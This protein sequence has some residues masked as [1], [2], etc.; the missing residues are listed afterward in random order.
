MLPRSC[1]APSPRGSP[2]ASLFRPAGLP[3]PCRG[4]L[5]H[6]RWWWHWWGGKAGQ[7]LSCSALPG[8]SA[9]CAVWRS[10]HSPATCRGQNLDALAAQACYAYCENSNPGTSPGVQCYGGKVNGQVRRGRAPTGRLRSTLPRISAVGSLPSFVGVDSSFHCAAY[11]LR[12]RYACALTLTPS[13]TRATK[14]AKCA[15]IS[16]NHG[17]AS[18]VKLYVQSAPRHALLTPTLAVQPSTGTVTAS[19]PPLQPLAYVAI[20]YAVFSYPPLTLLLT[21]PSKYWILTAIFPLLQPLIPFPRFTQFPPT[22]PL[23]LP[24]VSCTP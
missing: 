17:R 16:K 23:T 13:A 11:C 9:T 7:A 15:I 12:C 4:A 8:I 24:H 21:S 20:V 6:C 10:P 2:K 14:M 18:C 3:V 1:R 5:L 22:P 19:S